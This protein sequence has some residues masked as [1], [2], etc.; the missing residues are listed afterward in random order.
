M[1]VFA[2][3][4]RQLLFTGRMAEI[5]RRAAYIMDIT[6][7]TGKVC[8]MHG[9]PD[10][11]FMAAVLDNRSLMTGNSAKMTMSKASPVAGQAELHFMQGRHTTT[12][13]IIGMPWKRKILMSS[14]VPYLSR[15]LS[16][17]MRNIWDWM[18]PDWSQRIKKRSW[19]GNPGRKCVLWHRARKEQEGKSGRR[20]GTVRASGRG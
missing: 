15:D 9:L 2:D 8:H 16:G 7:K 11:R 10:Q 14:L 18:E 5:S 13:I 4:G 3:S 6:F 1:A 17:R 12:I 19:R 20:N